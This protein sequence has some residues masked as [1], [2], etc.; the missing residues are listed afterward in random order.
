MKIRGFAEQIQK[1]VAGGNVSPDFLIN[2]Y[3]FQN[4]KDGE[5]AIAPEFLKPF[6]NRE[7]LWDSKL[8]L[9]Y[10]ELPVTVVGGLPRDMG[11][12]FVS[13]QKGQDKSFVRIPSSG[14]SLFNDQIGNLGSRRGFMLESGPIYY[15]GIT[16]NE[17]VNKAKVLMKLI[18]TGDQYGFDDDVP[19]PG[20]MQFEAIELVSGL[21]MKGL[22]IPQDTINDTNKQ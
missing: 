7:I 14:L 3:T 10:S 8:D 2:K 20:D 16:E 19:I 9:Y 1:I 18:P 6:R 21:Y 11:V 15:K 5:F 22:Q 13:F 12:Y 17:Y 4:A